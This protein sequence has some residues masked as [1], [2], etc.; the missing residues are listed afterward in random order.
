MK[1]WPIV[2][3]FQIFNCCYSQKVG[4]MWLKFCRAL[5]IQYAQHITKNF[6]G[7]NYLF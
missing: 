3:E 4:E 1:N 2:A 6:R 5:V 7:Q